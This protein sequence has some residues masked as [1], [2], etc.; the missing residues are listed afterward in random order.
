MFAVG[1]AG[2]TAVLPFLRCN[3]VGRASQQQRTWSN[4]PTASGQ[5]PSADL[6]RQLDDDALGAADVAE[7][8]AVLVAHQL[9]D[10]LGAA[11]L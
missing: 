5:G 9:T 8:V 6:L 7:P 3:R 10:E 11:G 2:P 4:P 1:P